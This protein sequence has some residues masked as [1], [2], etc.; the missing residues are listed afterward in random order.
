MIPEEASKSVLVDSAPVPEGVDQV[1]GLDFDKNPDLECFL[2]SFKSSGYQATNLGL[3]MDTVNNMLSWTGKREDSSTGEMKDAKCTIWLSF[4]SNMISSGLREI[5]VYLAKN[6]LIDVVVTSAGGVEEDLVKVLAPTYI[7]EFSTKG[8]KLREKGWNRIG[9]LVVPNDNYCKFENWLQPILDQMLGEQQK[10][11][12][13]TPSKMIER[14]G[15]EIDNEDSLCYWCYKNSIPIFC[16]GLTDGSIGDNMFFHSYR[17]PGLICD[18]IQDIRAVNDIALRCTQSGVIILGGG[19]P[20]HHTLNANLMRNGADFAV[21][22]NTA[23]EY[24]GC[25]SG[26]NPDE[27]ISWGK[28]RSPA[29]PVKVHG[30]ATILFPLL[31]AG[32]FAK[33]NNKRN[34]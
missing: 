32:S 3:A 28:I 29:R 1:R 13:W 2:A 27:A 14:F 9:N 33:Q 11:A 19:L 16:P 26:A 30:D 15:K 25:D 21:Y 10:G 20:K 8:E 34:K 12:H 31:V 6:K 24:D 18:I 4:T 7:G 22:V 5:F 23:Q 17:N